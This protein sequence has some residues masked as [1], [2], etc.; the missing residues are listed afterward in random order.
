[1]ELRLHSSFVCANAS[2]R[3]GLIYRAFGSRNLEFMIGMFTTYIRPLLEYNTEIWS[4]CY[5]QDIDRIESIQRRF[6]KRI[7]GL[8]NKSYLERLVICGLDSLELRRIITDVVLVYKIMHNLVNL[9]FDDYFKF[10]PVVGTRGNSRKLYPAFARRNIVYNFFSN[11]VVNYWN[12]L[13]NYVVEAPSLN[14]FKKRLKEKQNLL[15]CFVRGHAI[16]NH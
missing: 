13:P 11:R 10:A 15:H 8:F 4:P 2:R 16:R 6:T 1:M 12:V 9:S 3:V 5:L 7:K 14:I